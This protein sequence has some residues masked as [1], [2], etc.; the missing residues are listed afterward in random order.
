MHIVVQISWGMRQLYMEHQVEGECGWI[1]WR[2][3]KGQILKSLVYG[4]RHLDIFTGNEEASK[5]AE[6]MIIYGNSEE[7]RLGMR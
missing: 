3:S 2:V 4:L 1:S 5:Q 6:G 7:T